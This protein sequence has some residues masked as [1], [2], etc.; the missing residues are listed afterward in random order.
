MSLTF[1]QQAFAFVDGLTFDLTQTKHSSLNNS[2]FLKAKLRDS[3]SF[4]D[5]RFIYP[6]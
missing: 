5:K 2:T 4:S 6:E 3:K 1:V